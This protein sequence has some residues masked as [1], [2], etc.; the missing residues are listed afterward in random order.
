VNTATMSALVNGMILSFILSIAIGI[1]FRLFGRMWNASTRYVAWLGALMLTVSFP[2]LLRIEN[3]TRPA[4]QIQ[5]TTGRWTNWLLVAW[6]FASAVMLRPRSAARA[7]QFPAA[8]GWP[9]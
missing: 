5:I 9:R 3:S 7:R 1:V 2:L 8:R 4:Y 6:T